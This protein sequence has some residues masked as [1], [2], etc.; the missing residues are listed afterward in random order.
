M[1]ENGGKSIKNG[2]ISWYFMVYD[3]NMS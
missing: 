3:W 2:G 1:V